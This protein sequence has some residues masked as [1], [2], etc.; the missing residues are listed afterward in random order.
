[1]KGTTTGTI[2]DVDGF[3]TLTVPA[4]GILLISFVGYLTE[5]ITIGD[6]T[7][8]DVTL[9]PDIAKLEEI[10]VIGYG[11]QKKSLLQFHCQSGR[12]GPGKLRFH[13]F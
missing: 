12:K 6:Q 3:F 5:E 9:L 4:D 10:V 7:N 8:V 2:T 13:A 1:V 11:V